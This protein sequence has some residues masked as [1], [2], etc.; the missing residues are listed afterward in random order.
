VERRGREDPRSRSRI[1]RT[2]SP[3]FSASCSCVRSRRRRACTSQ[4]ANDM[5]RG[6]PVELPVRSCQLPVVLPVVPSAPLI[7]SFHRGRGGAACGGLQHHPRSSGLV[8]LFG[9]FL[10]VVIP[11]LFTARIQKAIVGCRT[12]LLSCG[13]TDRGAR[14]CAAYRGKCGLWRLQQRV[15]RQA[16]RSGGFNRTNKDTIH[17]FSHPVRTRRGGSLTCVTETSPRSRSHAAQST[18]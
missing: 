17:P 3:A 8:P 1:A 4:S 10:A 7:D 14:P 15:S 13:T 9:G 2:L 18:P 6:Y 12:E 16:R 5:G 11:R